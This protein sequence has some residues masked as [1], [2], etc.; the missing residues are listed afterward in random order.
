M[1]IVSWNCRQKF[2]EKIVLLEVLKPDLMI[3]PECEDPRLYLDT[4]NI[5]TT[6]FLWTGDNSHK[7]LGVFA[8]EKGM[9]SPSAPGSSGA[10][11]AIAC[12]IG[13]YIN[14]VAVRTKQKSR[15]AN[16]Y[17]GQLQN[18]LK[19]HGRKILRGRSLLG[20]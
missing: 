1:R 7:G 2:R 12:T 18:M 11:L 5:G 17:V 19:D 8:R 6:N 15:C 3:V 4:F 9:I 14:L 13:N 20:W 16:S 10:K